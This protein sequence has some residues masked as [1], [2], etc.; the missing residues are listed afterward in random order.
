M[1]RLLFATVFVTLFSLAAL[2][3]IPRPSTPK[4]VKTPK[5]AKSI[6]TNLMIQLDRNAKEAKL[7]IPKSQIQRLRA[8]LDELDGG[9]NN[10]AAVSR[11]SF[12]GTQ[13]IVSGMFL[14]LAFVFGGVWLARSGK[15]VSKNG[16]ALGIGAFLFLGGAFATFVFAN[17]GPPP[18]ARSITGKMFTQAVHTYKFGSGAIKLEM[19]TDPD[20]DDVELIVPDP[21][22]DNKP[23]E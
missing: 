7:I 10:T 18:E 16:R 17:A 11:S 1:K 15:T 19:S 22:D 13:T 6:D 14:T 12:T 4:P 23:G 9:A 8:E 21:K 2:A 20:E 3:D 5:Q